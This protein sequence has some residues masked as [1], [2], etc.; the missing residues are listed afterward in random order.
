[1]DVWVAW[2]QEA[3]RAVLA[4]PA[5][6]FLGL[7]VLVTLWH[8]ARTVAW[9]RRMLRVR[10]HRPAA[11]VTR[12]LLGGLLAGAAV[13]AAGLGPGFALDARALAFFWIL[14]ALLAVFRLR[15][16]RAG[17]A[18]GLLAIGQLALSSLPVPRPE[19]ASL[20]WLAWVVD[21]WAGLDAMGLLLLAGLL[22][23]A[24]GLLLLAEKARF[25]HP[26]VMEGKRGKRIG[27]WEVTAVWPVPLLLLV[28]GDLAL[29]WVPVLA[30]DAGAGGWGLLL[31]PVPVG[32]GARTVA[33]WPE[34][35]ARFTA[36][37]SLLYGA[38]LAVFAAAA[39]LW[40]EEVPALP[41]VAA[42]AAVVLHELAA[43]WNRWR[44][45]GRRLLYVHDGRGM[46]ILAV[47]PGTA[48]AEMGL[49]CGEVIRR[50]NGVP[51][52]DRAQFHAALERQPAYAR[53]EVL[54]R[55]GEV[56]YAQRARYAGEPHML[57]VVPAPDGSEPAAFPARPLMLW[58]WLTGQGLLEAKPRGAA[59]DAAGPEAAKPAEAETAADAANPEA[60]GAAAEAAAEVASA[61]AARPENA[62]DA[63]ETAV[64]RG[65]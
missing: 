22:H 41:W 60:A 9:Q 18:A 56:R 52:S 42:A 53:L 40:R 36:R 38:V 62:A 2:L 20:A 55:S 48:A 23:L 50:V 15:L 17:M 49:R 26:L 65:G 1:M 39:G 64:R 3:G 14:L 4:L 35:K 57:G 51:V 47:Q 59:G 45:Q 43:L 37:L 58:H 33:F 46:A 27:A 10:M 31:F 19:E 16:A 6:P 7:C 25:A 12:R 34:D 29:P 8:I 61:E 44:E 24:E 54:D 21:A 28:P 11:L 30:A 63:A 13:S 5:L 32:A